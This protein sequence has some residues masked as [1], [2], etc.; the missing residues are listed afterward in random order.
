LV[1][2]PSTQLIYAA[3]VVAAVARVI[4]AFDI[5]REVLLA[6]SATAWVT[7]FGGFVLSYGPLLVKRRTDS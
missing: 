4:T 5:W 6:A 3:I 2:S 1:A 7:A